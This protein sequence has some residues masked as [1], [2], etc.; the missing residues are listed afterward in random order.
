MPS[1]GDGAEMHVSSP[2]KPELMLHLPRRSGKSAFGSS[3][4]LPL[5][6]LAF[7][8]VASDGLLGVEVLGEAL[9]LPELLGFESLGV[10]A[11]PLLGFESLGVA[12]PD[13]AGDVDVCDALSVGVAL[14]VGAAAAE[15]AVAPAPGAGALPSSEPQPSADPASTNKVNE[16]DA[17]VRA[18]VLVMEVSP[19]M[20]FAPARSTPMPKH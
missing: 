3:A 2:G 14:V 15:P 8:G 11:E 20:A 7:G 6:G 16:Q 17:S 18:Y 9:E 10:D 19:T 12:D 5:P 1:S 13:V 4:A